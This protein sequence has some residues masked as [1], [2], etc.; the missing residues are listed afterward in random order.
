MILPYRNHYS[1]TI[2]ILFEPLIRV[3]VGSSEEFSKSGGQ[4]GSYAVVVD[5]GRVI[6]HNNPIS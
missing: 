2:G 5:V 4:N 6:V 3:L 1:S